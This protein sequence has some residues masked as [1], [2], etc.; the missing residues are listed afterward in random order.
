MILIAFF[1]FSSPIDHVLVIV[2]GLLP[3]LDCSSL[4]WVTPRS[5]WSK[6]DLAVP[7]PSPKIKG[8]A[9]MGLSCSACRL[10]PCI[11]FLAS[12]LLHIVDAPKSSSSQRRQGDLDRSGAVRFNRPGPSFRF[13]CSQL[14][15][16]FLLTGQRIRD[17]CVSLS[18]SR[19][20]MLETYGRAVM[21][22]IRNLLA[23]H[24]SHLL[25]CRISPGPSLT[26]R[27]GPPSA[28]H[29]LPSDH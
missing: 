7:V 17:Q 1:C 22:W 27:G 5:I 8:L 25:A 20:V 11:V 24:R 21:A 15:P 10:G 28:A 26:Q 13:S 14:R 16:T 3:G 6:S 19:V 29:S 18:P 4:F 23:F 12:L 9:Y 2:L